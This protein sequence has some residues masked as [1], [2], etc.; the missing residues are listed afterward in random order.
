MKAHIFSLYA[1][2]FAEHCLHIGLR[3]SEQ[4]LQSESI[5]EAVQFAAFS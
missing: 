4:W 1:E 3:E 2:P 5:T